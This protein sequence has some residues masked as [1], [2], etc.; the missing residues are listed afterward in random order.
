MNEFVSEGETP[1]ETMKVDPALEEQQ[2]ARVR[3][4]RAARAQDGAQRALS[5]VKR[6]AQGTQNLVPLIVSAVKS[7]ATLGEIANSLRDVFG[8]HSR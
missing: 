5:E 8:E 7:R 3:A 2:V 6:G 1:F 4:F